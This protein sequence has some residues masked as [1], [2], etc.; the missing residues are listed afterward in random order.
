MSITSDSSLFWVIPILITSA[1]LAIWL[2]ANNSWFNGLEKRW[3]WILRLL[4][5]A[6][7]F[8]IGILLLGI[9]F[10]STSYR[11]E[12]PVLITLVDTSASMLNYSDSNKVKS[13]VND[14]I[15]K[16]ET[17]LGDKY[18]LVF[19][20][21]GNT[22]EYG[23]PTTFNS[24]ASNHSQSFE[25]IQTDFYNRNVGA[26]LFVSDG[27]F[28]K[29]AHPIYAA[30]KINFTPVYTLGVGDTIPKRDQVIKHVTSN[31]VVFLRNKF[32]IEV[33]LEGIKMGNSGASVSIFSNG[34]K[35]ASR[36]V[37]YS[38]GAYDFK[39]LTF[40]VEAKKTGIQTFT[41][42]VNK[43]TNEFNYSNNSKTIYVE[44][45][46]SRKSVLFISGAPH[47]DIAAIKDALEKDENL[48]IRTET[49]R[50]WDRKLD[51]VDLIIWHEPGIGFEQTIVDQIKSKK[52]PVWYVIGPYTN[53]SVISK[54][55]IGL[56]V[57]S[58]NQ[59]DEVQGG[60]VNGFSLFE[61]NERAK[62]AI[63]FFPPLRAKFGE[64]RLNSSAEIALVQKIGPIRKKEPLLFF[65]N[66]TSSRYAVL[67]GEGIWRWKMSDF[68]RNGNTESYSELIQKSTQYLLIEQYNSPFRVS[69]D[70]RYSK[71]DDVIFNATFYNAALEPITTPTV[72]LE[73]RNEKG[74]NIKNTFAKF[75]RFYKVSL[76]KMTPGKYNWKAYTTFQGKSYVKNGYFIVEDIRLEQIDNYAFNNHLK[77][78]SVGTGG[79]FY[80]LNAF[81]KSLNELKSRTDITSVSY[82]ESIYTD[83]ID[84]KSLFFILLALLSIEWFLR[85]WLG[86]Y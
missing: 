37:N 82:K 5:T 25:K 26:V 23:K 73:I 60:W 58:S 31:D 76:G 29:S 39:Q 71:E 64:V 84:W 2:Y 11:S 49:I 20:T 78:L 69:C 34:Q 50:T 40:E 21:S 55:D 28:N 6:S 19:M 17:G 83:L 42:V 36:T 65:G 45:V 10:E 30:Q 38:N 74:Q 24:I 13:N 7:L 53:S 52:L 9:I 4:R 80:R 61:L 68:Q 8:L 41:I 44:V 77:Q 16:I 51:G 46:D 14:L 33:D 79:E 47:P 3:K 75:D 22:T 54:L 72:Q 43:A 86:S 63:S 59:S 56:S 70:K 32:P 67:Y 62:E 81:E 48:Q 27:N 12:K 15:T 57:P 1:A 66:R 18:D 35:V 85:R